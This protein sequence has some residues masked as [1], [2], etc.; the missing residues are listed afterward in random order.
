MLSAYFFFS[1]LPS[2]NK[3]TFP[4]PSGGDPHNS[5]NN[6]MGRSAASTPKTPTKTPTTPNGLI[7]HRNTGLRLNPLTSA[8]DTTDVSSPQKS[9]PLVQKDILNDSPLLC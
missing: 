5:N 2:Y 9:S 6:K 1:D 3:P 8:F 7:D 4:S